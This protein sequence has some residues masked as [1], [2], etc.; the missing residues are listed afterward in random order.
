M[1]MH[2]HP[3]WSCPF[4]GSKGPRAFFRYFILGTNKLHPCK[5]M[6]KRNPY[7][8]R[9]IDI[10]IFPPVFVGVMLVAMAGFIYE[11]WGTPNE[12]EPEGSKVNG[13]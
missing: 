10:V 12:K 6:R 9:P 1:T 5:E 7:K 3:P 13:E 2:T 4:C 8:F 11:K